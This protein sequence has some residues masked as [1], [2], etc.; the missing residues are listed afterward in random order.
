MNNCVADDICGKSENNLLKL[1][2]P[3]HTGI[4]ET[5]H[6]PYTLQFSNNAMGETVSFTKAKLIFNQD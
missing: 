2:P 6:N 3:T 1:M 5:I 4:G